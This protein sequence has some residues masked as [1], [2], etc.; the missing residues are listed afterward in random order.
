MDQDLQPFE[1]ILKSMGID[2]FE[3]AVPLALH[4]YAKSK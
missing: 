4:E 2:N 3:E 1:N